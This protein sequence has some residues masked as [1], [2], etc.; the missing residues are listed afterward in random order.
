MKACACWDCSKATSGMNERRRWSVALQ[1]IVER[2]MIYS[3]SRFRLRGGSQRSHE[4]ARGR[5]PESRSEV[6][7]MTRVKCGAKIS[8]I[9]GDQPGIYRKYSES[10]GARAAYHNP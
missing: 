9:W 2:L 5:P 3:P 8:S 10:R 6:A 4:G 1:I 7:P